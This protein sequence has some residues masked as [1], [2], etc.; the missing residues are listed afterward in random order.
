[1]WFAF[2]AFD[3]DG[4]GTVSVD[5]IEAIVR[6]VEAGLLAK[7]Q[8]DNLVGNIRNELKTIVTSDVDFDQFVY[9]MTTPTGQQTGGE[10][11]PWCTSDVEPPS[12]TPVSARAVPFHRPCAHFLSHRIR[13]VGAAQQALER[14]FR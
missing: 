14:R 7:E 3:R 8:V 4:S 10:P 11:V 2:N 5:E 12:S 6:H 9:I 1:M 13:R